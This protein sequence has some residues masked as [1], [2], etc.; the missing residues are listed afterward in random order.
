MT[1]WSVGVE[2]EGDRE[3]TQ[4]EILALAYAVATSGGIASGIGTPRYGARLVVVADTRE[5]AEAKAR[6]EF[7]AA[8]RTAN[9]PPWPITRL[10]TTNEHEDT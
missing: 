4:D 2:A 9:L 6:T 3:I 8:A 5:S 7:T 10:E 1:R